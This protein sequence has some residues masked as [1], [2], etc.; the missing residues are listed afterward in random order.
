MANDPEQEH[1]NIYFGGLPCYISVAAKQNYVRLFL[2][3]AD[4]RK[5]ANSPFENCQYV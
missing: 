3:Q 5:N 1:I 4:K 2:K